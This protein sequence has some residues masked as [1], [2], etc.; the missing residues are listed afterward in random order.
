MVEMQMGAKDVGDVLKAQARGAETVE[1]GLLGEVV[2]SRIAF[3][4]AGAGIDQD[5]EPGRAHKERLVG[6]HHAAADRIEHDGVEFCEVFTPQ[7]GIVGREHNLRRAPG[8]VAL[9]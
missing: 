1:P 5:G 9:D 4:L 8:T 7:L 6:D 3:V 2:G